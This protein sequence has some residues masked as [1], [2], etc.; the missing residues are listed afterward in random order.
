MLVGVKALK[1]NL[2]MSHDGQKLFLPS[3]GFISETVQGMDILTF[4]G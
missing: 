1:A 4:I 2:D 3:S